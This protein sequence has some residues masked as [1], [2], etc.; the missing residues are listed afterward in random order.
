MRDRRICA[1]LKDLRPSRAPFSIGEIGFFLSDILILF[2]N[3]LIFF[4]D[5]FLC[6]GDILIGDCSGFTCYCSGFSVPSLIPGNQG[7]KTKHNRCDH[8]YRHGNNQP[9][10]VSGGSDPT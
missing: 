2:G 4:R 9:A 6:G 5:C 3:S 10:L 7:C 1:R 8:Q